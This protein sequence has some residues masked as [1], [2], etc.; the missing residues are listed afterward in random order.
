MPSL[1]PWQCFGVSPAA[2]ASMLLRRCGRV[3]ALLNPIENLT[4]L[5]DKSIKALA[6][7]VFDSARLQEHEAAINALGGASQACAQ[8]NVIGRD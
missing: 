1:R 4:Q 7:F 8:P 5:S 6:F 3:T 2:S